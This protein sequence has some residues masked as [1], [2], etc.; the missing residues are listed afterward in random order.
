MKTLSGLVESAFRTGKEFFT[1][2]GFCF[3]ESTEAAC[4]L[5]KVALLM[6]DVDNLD[7][8]L[9]AQVYSCEFPMTGFALAIDAG[10]C[11]GAAADFTFSHIHP[12]IRGALPSI[13]S[14][15]FVPSV[16]LLWT[17]AARAL[18]LYPVTDI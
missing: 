9:T 1:L 4:L 15:A 3:Q 11:L 13:G 14:T 6:D 5:N 10:D 8:A 2:M 7:H 17:L 16:G 12:F 18:L